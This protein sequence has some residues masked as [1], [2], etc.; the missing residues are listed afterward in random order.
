[1]P[2]LYREGGHF[3][4]DVVSTQEVR[5][6]VWVGGCTYTA[7]TGNS[8]EQAAARM[9]RRSRVACMCRSASTSTIS[10]EESKA[11]QGS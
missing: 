11:D 1:V 4:S 3:A 2:V 7:Q 10:S 5:E 8:G 9:G 6:W